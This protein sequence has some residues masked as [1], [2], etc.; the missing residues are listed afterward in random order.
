MVYENILKGKFL[1]RPNRFIAHVETGEGM[2]ICHVKNT[3]R[4]RELLIPGCAVWLSG[5]DNPARKTRYDLIGVEKE[6]PHGILPV[7]MDSQAP[8]R[9]FGEWAAAGGLGFVPDLLRPEVRY[10]DSRFDFYWE[11]GKE[12]GFWEVKGVTLE[13]NGV[14]R[15]PDA[16]TLRG[17]KHLEELIRAKEAGYRAGGVLC[18]T[19]A[20]YEMGGTKRRHPSSVWG[21]PAP[22]GGSGRGGAGGG[23]RRHS[24]IASHLWKGARGIVKKGWSGEAVPSVFWSTKSG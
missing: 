21:G 2:E 19:D 7:N 10:G 22:G 8:N 3:G 14:A 4:C 13:E 1:A 18:G 23:M 16:P 12:R 11:R 20:R 15:F 9:V 5:S 6:T 17:V 24:R